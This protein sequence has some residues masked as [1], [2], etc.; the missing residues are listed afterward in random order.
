M[1]AGRQDVAHLAVE[2]MRLKNRARGCRVIHLRDYLLG[3]PMDVHHR[4]AEQGTLTR[5]GLL[6]TTQSLPQ[7]GEGAIDVT[8]RCSQCG[9]RPGDCLLHLPFFAQEAASRHHFCVST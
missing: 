5:R 2:G 4:Q 3:H 6:P 8:A 9:L 7:L 1:L